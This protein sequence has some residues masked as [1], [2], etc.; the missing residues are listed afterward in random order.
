M[1]TR[2]ARKNYRTVMFSAVIVLLC[3]LIAVLAWPEA[4]I[5]AVP[6]SSEVKPAENNENYGSPQQEEDVKDSNAGILLEPEENLI[7]N[8]ENS[9]NLSTES[10]YLVK[11]MGQEI[12]VF[13]CDSHGNMVQLETTEI[14]Y[15]ML[16]PGDQK[17]FDQGIQVKSQEELGTLL[18]DFEG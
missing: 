3:I 15:D 13:F 14:I 8:E 18:Q 16:G 10:Y 17:L 7:E 4:P 1:F 2:R 5:E 11:R 6:G 9:M 12:A